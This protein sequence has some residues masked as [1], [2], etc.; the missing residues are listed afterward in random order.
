MLKGYNFVQGH[1]CASGTVHEVIADIF[2]VIKR[3]C[4]CSD[5][6]DDDSGW[7]VGKLSNYLLVNDD[8]LNAVLHPI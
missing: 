4:S 8:Q 6:P 1:S 5:S 2:V 7:W 3:F